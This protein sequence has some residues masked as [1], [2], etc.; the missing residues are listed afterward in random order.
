MWGTCLTTYTGRPVYWHRGRDLS[1]YW[2]RGRGLYVLVLVQGEWPQCLLAKGRAFVPIGT[3]GGASVPI[4][5]ARSTW[6]LKVSWQ[7]TG[8]PGCVVWCGCGMREG[9]GV[10]LHALAFVE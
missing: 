6:F 5:T 8:L 4:G 7:E 10:T 3:G 1:T 2:H 9:A